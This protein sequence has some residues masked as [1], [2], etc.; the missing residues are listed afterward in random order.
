MSRL[1]L[2]EPCESRAFDVVTFGEN[3]LDFVGAGP[4]PP[5]GADKSTLTSF[6]LLVGGQATTA[7][8]A[9]ARQGLRTRYVG[10]FGNDNWGMTVK[11]ALAVEH[12]DLVAI[13]RSSAR[14]RVAVVLVD[15][16]SGDRTVFEFRD[17]ALSIDESAVPVEA[18]LSGRV[19]ML[20]ATD[21]GTSTFIARRA[22]AAGVPTI[23]DVDRVTPDV[24][25]LLAEIS[26]I[27]VPYAFLVAWTG[28]GSPG[29]ALAA[30]M[31]EFNPA[32]AIVTLGA[33]GSLALADGRE[34]MTKA[35]SVKAVDTTGAGDAFRAG[36]ASAWV[37][38]ADNPDLA[39]ILEFANATAALNCCGVGAIASL[40]RFADV[41]AF[42]T[43]A[44]RG[45][46]K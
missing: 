37:R 13:E 22:R 29:D 6:D 41:E 24:R 46:S 5:A 15:S 19:L 26:V 12:V 32:A 36:L 8:V 23:V 35:F 39:Q 18:L 3:S 34:V 33:E 25:D 11:A 43:R 42:V 38:M 4:R 45:Q 21:L 7:A 28:L 16:D 9:C 2:L 20:D 40:P 31:R 17:P 14:S 30:L 10:A 1:P 44:G 27:V